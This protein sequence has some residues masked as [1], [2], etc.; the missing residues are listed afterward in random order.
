MSTILYAD[1]E[2]EHRLMMQVILKNQNITLLEAANGE[3]ALEKIERHQPDL[4]LLD[5]FMPR[6]DGFG[7]LK[8]VK[9]NPATRHIPIIIL[10][11]WPTGDNLEQAINMGA[12]YFLAKPYDP[13]R[14][15]KMIKHYLPLLEVK[16]PAK[17]TK[18]DTAPLNL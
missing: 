3:E 13:F 2:I 14:L 7:V 5:L 1:D 9:T 8:A 10:S 4:V 15:V 6:I 12:A 18:K 16:N 11:A 17:V